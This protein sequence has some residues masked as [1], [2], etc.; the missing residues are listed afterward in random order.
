MKRRCDTANLS[1]FKEL[2]HHVVPVPMLEIYDGS[3]DT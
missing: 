1:T 3:T 2:N